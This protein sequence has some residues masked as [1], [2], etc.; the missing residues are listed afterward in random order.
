VQG[1]HTLKAGYQHTF[2]TFNSSGTTFGSA[3]FNFNRG[4]TQG[5]NPNQASAL[6]GNGLASFI[7]GTPASG[8]NILQS[9]TT[10]GQQVHALFVQ[11]D[12]KT[13]S[14]LTLNLGMRW[15]Y[16]GP[17]TDRHNVFTNFDPGIQSPLQVPG[18]TLRGGAV[19]PPWQDGPRG[20]TETS[21]RRFAPRVGFAYQ[22]RH[23]LVARGGYGITFIPTKGTGINITGFRSETV[24]ATS[25][26]GGLTPFHT[27]RDP[28][29]NGLVQPTGASLGALT[30]V[31]AIMQ[32]Q[33]RNVIPGYLQ[34]WN[35]TLQYSPWA[36]WLIEGA[37]VASKGTHLL[38]LQNRDFNQLH[39]QYL[40]LGN[41]L[42]RSVPN[43][44]RGII[45]TGPLSGATIP[46]QQLLRPHP[47]FT[48]VQGGYSFLG[49]S[50]YHAFAFK[51]E[52]R[53][54]QGFSLLTAYTISKLIDALA[55]SPGMSRPGGEPNTGVVNWYDLRRE[56][57]KGIEDVPQRLVFT[58]LWALPYGQNMSGWQINSI[59]TIQSGSPIALIAPGT[60]G[61]IGTNRPNVV[62]GE[63]PR[64]DNP[65]IA[66]WFNT[67][68]FSVPA[69]F[70]FGNASR[71]LPNALTDGL[72]NMDLS[73]LKDFRI[74]EGTRLQFRAEAFNLTNTPT[75]GTPDRNVASRTFGVVNAAAFYPKPR[76]VQLALRYIF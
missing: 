50:I 57:S 15:E 52:K 13:T 6:A 4:F 63:N 65:T 69:P 27:V 48:D 11:E 72:F 16:E 55:G 47:Q 75:F 60:S 10:W 43:P 58:A 3:N 22:A 19:Y 29:P 62:A 17:V 26:D 66:R 32:G 49:D 12:W 70:T 74:T 76:E 8:T 28:Y 25:I 37:Y 56:R 9:D 46:L 59:T 71:T 44:F 23:D 31:G 34:Q 21:F 73:I 14:R 61:A 35:F 39:P 7:L 54:S 40:E 33:D 20:I 45:S 41:D 51:L 1:A 5:P 24:M 36:N 2:Y 30:G 38:T 67:A 18:L 42:V 53:F 64:I 68:A